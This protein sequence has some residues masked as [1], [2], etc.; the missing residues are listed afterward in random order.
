[1]RHEGMLKDVWSICIYLYVER[2]NE[3]SDTTR[4]TRTI[5]KRVTVCKESLSDSCR[6]TWVDAWVCCYSVQVW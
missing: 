4:Y 2:P 5:S 3:L 1:M 6:V